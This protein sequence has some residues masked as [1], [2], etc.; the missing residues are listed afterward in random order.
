MGLFGAKPELINYAFSPEGALQLLT[1]YKN[2][3][4]PKKGL[5]IGWIEP[6]KLAALEPSKLVVTTQHGAVVIYKGALTPE[7]LVELIKGRL[8]GQ[9]EVIKNLAHLE[10]ERQKQEQHHMNQILNGE[11]HD[12]Y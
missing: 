6:D 8:T 10:K 9:N 4:V 12:T 3:D 1:I 7:Q 2:M 11:T 5:H